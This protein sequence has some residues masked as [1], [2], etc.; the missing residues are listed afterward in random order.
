MRVLKAVDSIEPVDE[1]R[2]FIGKHKYINN[3]IISVYKIC[4]CFNINVANSDINIELG[5]HL[6]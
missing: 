1:Y 3:I 6:R 5:Q 2:D 4:I